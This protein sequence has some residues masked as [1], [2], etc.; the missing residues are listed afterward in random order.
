MSHGDGGAPVTGGAG[1][2]VMQ[3]QRGKE[4]VRHTP[5]TSHDAQRI[6]LPRRWSINARGGS[7]FWW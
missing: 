7:I 5:L 3:H 4:R 2:G 1:G 6:G